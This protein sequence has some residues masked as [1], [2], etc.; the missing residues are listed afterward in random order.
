MLQCCMILCCLFCM[1]SSS[2]F[3]EDLSFALVFRDCH[4]FVLSFQDDVAAERAI[5]RAIKEVRDQIDKGA[6]D[7]KLIEN[8]S[9]VWNFT[10]DSSLF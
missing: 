7:C 1:A 10:F 9:M 4:S 2:R 8:S 5:E 6:A 3:I